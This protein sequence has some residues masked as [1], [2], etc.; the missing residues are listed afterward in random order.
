MQIEAVGLELRLLVEQYRID[1]E[2]DRGPWVND[3][4]HLRPNG[5]QVLPSEEA[6][7]P[8]EDQSHL[9]EHPN[10]EAVD[11]LDAGHLLADQNRLVGD[12]NL[13][14][15]LSCGVENLECISD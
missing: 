5:L 14:L 13:L 10:H 12:Q 1:L 15:G 2:M 8:L 7:L 4:D 6:G 11:L 3:V 9:V